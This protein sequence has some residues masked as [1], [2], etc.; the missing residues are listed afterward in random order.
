MKQNNNEKYSQ[1]M[2]FQWNQHKEF[3]S[4]IIYSV[5]YFICPLYT[6]PHSSYNFPEGGFFPSAGRST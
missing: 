6:E 5:H 1:I 4:Y 3:Y 2:F